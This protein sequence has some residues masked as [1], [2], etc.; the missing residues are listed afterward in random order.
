MKDAVKTA[1]SSD[2][3]YYEWKK[4]ASQPAVAKPIRPATADDEEWAEFIAIEEENRRLRKLLSEKLRIE[5][6]DLRKRL[7]LK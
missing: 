5:N 7:G 4:A 6:A 3:R 2:Q 1:G